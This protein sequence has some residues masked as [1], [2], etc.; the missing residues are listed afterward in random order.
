MT[1]SEGRRT[2]T[3]RR[4]PALDGLRGVAILAVLVYH[5]IMYGTRLWP[6]GTDAELAVLSL[7]RFGEHGV[8]LFFVL[9]G[10]LITGILI[11]ASAASPAEYYGHFYARRARR[12]LPTY[13]VTVLVCLAVLPA[14]WPGRAEFAVPSGSTTWIATFLVNVAVAH[15]GWAAVPVVLGPLWSL[16]VEE[17]FYLVWPWLVR[18]RPPAQLLVL[19]V[20]AVLLA[21]VTR[22]I[23]L[24]RPP[25][26]QWE[27]LTPACA[28]MLAA[29]AVVAVLVRDAQWR[30]RL[31][32][33]APAVAIVAAILWWLLPLLDHRSVLDVPAIAVR[34]T[35]LA[36]LFAACLATVVAAPAGRMARALSARPLRFFGRYSYAIY[37][38]NQ[39]VMVAWYTTPAL[40]AVTARVGGGGFGAVVV[41]AVA[42]TAVTTAL[43]VGNWVAY[44]RRILA[45]GRPDRSSLAPPITFW[46]WLSKR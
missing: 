3:D 23:G 13:V 21:F 29:G 8:S 16:S 37:L 42:T 40:V 38:F 33:W 10:F 44:E 18:R 11:D 28:D 46:P 4:L 19:A 25:L 22:V 30:G 34:P 7:S 12:I 9:S 17:Q 26:W 41:F 32:V 43:A 1:G 15:S 36:T 35:V 27:L 2:V 20:A 31:A 24:G 6:P 39:P 14:L 5:G 45:G